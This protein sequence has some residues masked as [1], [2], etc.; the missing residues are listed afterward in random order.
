MQVVTICYIRVTRDED[1]VT[2]EFCP[3]HVSGHQSDWPRNS[4]HIFTRFRFSSLMLT[5]ARQ[6]PRAPG[7]H[8][9][10]DKPNFVLA[11]SVQYLGI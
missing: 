7:E 10:N 6:D 9:K 5:H 8:D 1:F 11:S 4:C 2:S 3:G